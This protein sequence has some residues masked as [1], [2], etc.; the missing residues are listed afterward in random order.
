MR[1]LQ[2]QITDNETVDLPAA[3]A[4]CRLQGAGSRRRPRSGS[5]CPDA[6]AALGS[7]APAFAAG[8]RGPKATGF[9]VER[10]PTATGPEPARIHTDDCRHF[11][12]KR[13]IIAHDA[14][15]ALPDPVVT[16]TLFRERHQR[17]HP[18]P[19]PGRRRP[20]HGLLIPRP[21]EGRAD[22][23]RGRGEGAHRP[24]GRPGSQ[25][26]LAHGDPPASQ[27]A[28]QLGFTSATKLQQVLPSAHRPVSD[29]LSR[30][31]P[32]PFSGGWTGRYARYRATPP[33]RAA[34]ARGAI[35]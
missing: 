22:R 6:P 26:L 30:D 5:A 3:S 14:R 19:L 20:S 31:R 1:H 15:A 10:Q 29:R 12:P 9:V 25:T 13:P 7:P 8:R 34:P 16:R 18:H 33:V 24:A 27:I 23:S 17:L 2:E 21:L 11:G 28:A 4:R 32:P 35:R